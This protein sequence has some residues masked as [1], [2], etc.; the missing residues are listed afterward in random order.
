M[1]LNEYQD[2]VNK[3]RRIFKYT[4]N[5]N[6]NTEVMMG[7]AAECGEVYN[8]YQKAIREN[9]N[10]LNQ[11]EM[12]DLMLELGDVIYYVTAIASIHNIDLDVIFQSNVAKLISRHKELT[13]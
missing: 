12:L 13:L 4:S 6:N 10:V 7:L 3:T 8:I 11:R 5:K 2:F 1:D 9:R